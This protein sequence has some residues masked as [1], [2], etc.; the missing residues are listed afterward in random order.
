MS[1]VYEE[2]LLEAWAKLSEGVWTDEGIR[3]A[4]ERMIELLNK[5]SNRTR[6]HRWALWLMRRDDE[7]CLKTVEKVWVVLRE[8]GAVIGEEEEGSID[9]DY[10]K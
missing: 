5:T 4:I 3:D 10:G 9:G 7:L 2:K 6:V 1:G 8:Q